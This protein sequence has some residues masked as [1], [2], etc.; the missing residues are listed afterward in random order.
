MPSAM[1]HKQ[2]AFL[3]RAEKMCTLKTS[4]RVLILTI[5]TSEKQTN[6]QSKKLSNYKTKPSSIEL[7]LTLFTR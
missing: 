4:Y 5:K 7:E 1:L 2:L 6:Y 3:C